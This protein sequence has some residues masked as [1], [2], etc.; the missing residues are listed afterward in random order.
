MTIEGSIFKNQRLQ[1][2]SDM[3]SASPNKINLENNNCDLDQTNKTTET[4]QKNKE[5][6]INDETLSNRNT[7]NKKKKGVF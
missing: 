2:L 7:S 3:S 5:K 4:Y 6:K 1:T